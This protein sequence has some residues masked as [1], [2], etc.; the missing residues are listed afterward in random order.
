MSAHEPRLLATC[1]TTAGDAAPGVGDERSPL[2]LHHRM[3]TAAAAGWSG[4]GLVHA[5]L[6]AHR[7]R[8]GLEDIAAIARDAG[9]E[10]IELEFIGD[11]W[12]RGERRAASD[13]VRDDL[14]EAAAVLG[15]P[16]VKIATAMDE[17]PP[18]QLFLDELAALSA[19]AGDDGVRLA[20]EPMPF[21]T[22]V[23]TIDDGA[24]LLDLLGDT[25]VGLCVDIWHVFRSGTAYSRIPQVLRGDQIFVVELDDGA[26]EP[27]GS[28]WD[29]TVDRRRYPGDG[30]FDVP[31]FI[32]AVRLSGFDGY[33]GV[34]IISADHRSRPIASSLPEL[35][36]A[37]LATFAEAS[38]DTSTES[39]RA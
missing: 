4:F 27:E 22:N 36:Q 31:S 24:R 20:L 37:T 35:A 6:V 25:N 15:A 11:W 30:A 7:E 21:S 29:D 34:E 14:F 23:R 10:R 12:T 1:W 9:I 3:R 2:D 16:V 26:S 28:L 39:D 33:W 18:E 38:R 13:R 32:R 19:R 5:D 8:G 17:P